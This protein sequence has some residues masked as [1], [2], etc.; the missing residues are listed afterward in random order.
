MPE[1][2]QSPTL[3]VRRRRMPRFKLHR[4]QAMRFF[5]TDAELRLWIGLRCSKLGVKFR[6]QVLMWGYIADFYC[7]RARLCVEV[8]G[9]VHDAVADRRRD[10]VLES[11]GIRTLRFSN[12]R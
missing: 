12:A 9:P 11:H 7:T 8:D 4:A 2:L 1:V 5:P 3:G 10:G 6:R